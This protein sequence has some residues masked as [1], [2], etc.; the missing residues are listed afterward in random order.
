[1]CVYLCVIYS[2]YSPSSSFAAL[3][4]SRY[5]IVNFSKKEFKVAVSDVNFRD[6]GVYTCL[7]YHHKHKN[8]ATKR[9]KVIVLGKCKRCAQLCSIMAL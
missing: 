2:I 5:S 8:V 4:D 9:V 7:H 1:M 3:K 6:G